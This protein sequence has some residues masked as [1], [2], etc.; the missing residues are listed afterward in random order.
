MSTEK[1]KEIVLLEKKVNKIAIDVE[2]IKIVDEHSMLVAAEKRKELKQYLK[3]AVAAKKE[4]TDPLNGVLKTIRG[5]FAPIEEKVE[6]A[7]SRIESLMSM[8]NREVEARRLKAEK[9]AQDKIDKAN[10]ELEAGRISEKQAEK[11]IEK[12]EIKLEKAP[13]VIKSS[14]SFHTRKIRKVKF[15]SPIQIGTSNLRY[16][17]DHG[18]IVWDEVKARKDALAGINV[19]ETEI[20]EEESFV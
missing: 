5:W 19:P 13:E 9:E 7:I 8:Y 18:Y 6:T 10:A 20:Y 2:N 4:A 14:D 17:V 16:L 1:S 3:D 12:A 11:V 15:N